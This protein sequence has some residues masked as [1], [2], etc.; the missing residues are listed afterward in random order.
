ME[1]I[2]TPWADG[3]AGVTQCAISPGE[4]FTYNFTVDKVNIF[5]LFHF[6]KNVN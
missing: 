3:A 6:Y 2:G 4:T 5:F 1:Q